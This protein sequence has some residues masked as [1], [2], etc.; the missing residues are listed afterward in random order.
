MRIPMLH[1]ET[2]CWPKFCFNRIVQVP[3]KF[4]WVLLVR[5]TS[6]NGPQTKIGRQDYY[7]KMVFLLSLVFTGFK[8]FA[9]SS[10]SDQYLKQCGGKIYS[11]C[12]SKELNQKTIYDEAKNSAIKSNKQVM[13][14]VGADWCPACVNFANLLST[15]K[16][17]SKLYEKYNVIKINGDLSS[18]KE[19]AEKLKISIVGFPQ[20]FIINPQNDRS[21]IQFFPSYFDS[22]AKI[23]LSINSIAK[24][25]AEKTKPKEVGDV[26]VSSLEKPIRL[27]NNYGIST[28]IEK[29]SSDAE[30]Y[31]NQGFAAFNVYHY[32]DAFR[33]FNEAE[34]KNPDFI[35]AQIGKVLAISKIDISNG[36]E[37]FMD[38]ALGK[39]ED[40][41]KRKPLTE[42][43]AA[44]VDFAKTIRFNISSGMVRTS[45]QKL[46]TMKESTEQIFNIDRTNIEGISIAVW[47]N[48]SSLKIE[49]AKAYFESVLKI[50]P[51]N[52]N[53][54]HSLLH[55]AEMENNQKEATLHATQLAR[56]APKSAHAQH[57]FGHT[58]P[59]KGQWKEALE[60]FKKADRIHE[61]WAKK[62]KL[63]IYQDWHY[64]HNQDLMASVY[65]GLNDAK[66]AFDAWMKA[67]KTDSRALMKLIALVL[68]IGDPAKTNEYLDYY[69]K[70]G[71]KEYIKDIRME[72]EL[73]PQNAQQ[74]N[75][76]ELNSHN[77]KYL[78]LVE[79][80]LKASASKNRSQELTKQATD[81]FSERFKAGGFDGWSHAYL[82]L[83]RIRRIAS[84]LSMNWL[85]EDLNPLEFA[86]QNGSL[87]SESTKSNSLTNCIKTKSKN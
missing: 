36:A 85:I 35:M 48:I 4:Y 69:E 83:H 74:I 31:I 21:E 24:P 29:P 10:Q 39:I 30:R 86:V 34:K 65:L 15:D 38:E 66:S 68:L 87:C 23:L 55:I 71:W 26:L 58:L 42:I 46:L 20:A 63:D 32:L 57:M 56:L 79:K 11:K 70:N 72:A 45:G 41:A 53:S 1:Y 76:K 3:V 12:N 19:L 7:M 37:Y 60:Y 49:D 47:N 6:A 44:W 18:G 80:I 43:E 75:F 61:E 25:V 16:D 84:I 40:R 9:E 51:S 82:E 78:A 33:S 67:S 62:N 2:F 77:S 22:I 14:I 52:I 13:V 27:E 8:T 64:A 28:F 54:H 50:Q 81:Y 17:S 5:L 73:T 59:Q